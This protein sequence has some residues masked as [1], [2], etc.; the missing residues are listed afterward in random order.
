LPQVLTLINKDKQK[1]EGQMQIFKIFS[2]IENCP[3]HLV[4][5]HRK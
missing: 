1:T 3:P 5:S 4:S 2:D